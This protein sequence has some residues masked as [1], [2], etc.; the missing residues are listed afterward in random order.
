MLREVAEAALR[1]SGSA[2][3]LPKQVILDELCKLAVWHRANA[4]GAA[5][6]LK[7]PKPKAGRETR[8][9]VSDESGI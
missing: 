6:D 2:A 4:Q 3:R 1:W 8:A 7:L 5:T 9:Q